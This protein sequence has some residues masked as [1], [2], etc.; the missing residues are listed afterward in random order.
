MWCV[1]CIPAQTTTS[2]ES[3]EWANHSVRF[4]V[5]PEDTQAAAQAPVHTQCTA[6]PASAAAVPRLI[7]CEFSCLILSRDVDPRPEQPTLLGYS[8]AVKILAPSLH[9]YGKIC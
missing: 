8:G 7:L 5:G 1:W 3:Q 4:P 2:T 9:P 6:A